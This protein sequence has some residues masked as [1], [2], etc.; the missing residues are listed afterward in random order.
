M[1]FDQVNFHNAT[2]LYA[3]TETPIGIRNFDLGV[4][5]MGGK[6]T[7]AVSPLESNNDV[8]EVSDDDLFDLERAVIVLE[9]DEVYALLR[10]ARLTDIFA[11]RREAKELPVIEN[12]ETRNQ[13]SE[14][15]AN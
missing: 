5:V 11:A 14:L 9:E 4:L 15:F 2:V 13:I 1:F 10:G 7:P 12:E 8:V 6:T 3:E